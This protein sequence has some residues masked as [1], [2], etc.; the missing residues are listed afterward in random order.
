MMD[1]VQVHCCLVFC[2][3]VLGAGQVCPA[4]LFFW[5]IVGFLSGLRS[6]FVAASFVSLPDLFS[7]L[8]LCKLR[9]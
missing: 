6:L 5:A 8:A 2:S 9:L 1:L 7:C 3:F 4:R